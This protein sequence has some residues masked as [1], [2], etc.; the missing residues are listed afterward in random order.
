MCWDMLED[1]C[2]GP[3]QTLYR[4]DCVMTYAL[5]DGRGDDYNLALERT[6]GFGV[7]AAW[8]KVS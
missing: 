5:Q 1:Q 3:E 2:Y 6:C 4:S 8:E 7:P